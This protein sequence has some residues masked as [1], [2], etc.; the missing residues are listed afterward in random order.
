MNNRTPPWYAPLKTRTFS[1]P[2]RIFAAAIAMRL[3]S[4]PEL[5]K[6]T[7]SMDGNR[8]QMVSAREK[9]FAPGDVRLIPLSRTDLS[10]DRISLL[11]WPKRPAYPTGRLNSTVRGNTRCQ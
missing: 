1:R 4:V 2:V 11:E 3:A 7:R 9:S 8:E 10:A 6:R 5:V